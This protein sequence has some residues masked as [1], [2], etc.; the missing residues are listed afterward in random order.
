MRYLFFTQQLILFRLFYGYGMIVLIEI[1][2][3]IVYFLR[4]LQ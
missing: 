4:D 1:T 2:G 3:N